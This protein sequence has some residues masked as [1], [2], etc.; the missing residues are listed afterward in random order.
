MPWIAGG[1]PV[2]MEVLLVFVVV[3]TVASAVPM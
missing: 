3:G 2:T 1:T